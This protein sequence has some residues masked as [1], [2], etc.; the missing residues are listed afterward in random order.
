MQQEKEQCENAVLVLIKTKTALIEKNAVMLREL[1]D[2]TIRSTCFFQNEGSVIT[3]VIVYTLARL[4][5]RQK[6]TEIKEWD[7]F[8]KKFCNIV[9]LTID[10]LQKDNL[11]AYSTEMG[12]TIKLLKSIAPNLKKYIEE[13]IQ[14]ASVNK[15]SEI[16][17][18]GI[19]LS[20]TA[21]LLGISQW[22]ITEY[23]GT[24][25]TADLKQNESIPVKKRAEMALK[26]L[27]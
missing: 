15:A 24:K 18:K 6:Y 12:R 21:E 3:A 13:S 25:E 8:V 22:E 10:A 14:K 19:S 1:S 2:R 9:D 11:E 20:R 26:F 23:I 17:D 16:Y 7:L 5:E 27:S 4:I